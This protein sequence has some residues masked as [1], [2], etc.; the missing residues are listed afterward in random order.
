[1]RAYLVCMRVR[2]HM[3]VCMCVRPK[4]HPRNPNKQ[5]HNVKKEAHFGNK[6][7]TPPQLCA[8]ALQYTQGGPFL[9]CVAQRITTPC[10]PGMEG[11]K[12][13]FIS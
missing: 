9:S 1:M 5:L 13:R 7:S 3:H 6:Q 10:F 2:V 4:R 8:I 12:K 11:G